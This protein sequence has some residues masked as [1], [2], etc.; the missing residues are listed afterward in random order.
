MGAGV[1][2]AS[3]NIQ[4]LAGVKVDIAFLHL[5]RKGPKLSGMRKIIRLFNEAVTEARKLNLP[6]D[7][8]PEVLR[9]VLEEDPSPHLPIFQELSGNSGCSIPLSSPNTALV[10]QALGEKC[11]LSILMRRLHFLTTLGIG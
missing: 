4:L 11:V 10:V 9:G 5:H 3:R 2:G 1:K 6:I 7:G 8:V